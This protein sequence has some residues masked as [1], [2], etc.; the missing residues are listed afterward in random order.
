M[1][2][3][4]RTTR[5]LLLEYDSSRVPYH[6]R[7]GGLALIYPWENNDRAILGKQMLEVARSHGFTGD[8][9]QFW[10]LFGNG[11]VINGNISS[12][13][14]P[15]EIKNLYVDTITGIVYYFTIINKE[16]VPEDFETKGGAIKVG[17]LTLE[18]GQEQYYFYAPIRTLLI[19]NTVLDGGKA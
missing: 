15:G 8:A 9:E 12:F 10:G 14:I 5:D 11:Q 7:Q 2:D 6:Y 13:P 1:S 4:R 16:E 19:E 17:T 18:N 3:S